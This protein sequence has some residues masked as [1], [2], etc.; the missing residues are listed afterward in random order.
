MD[1]IAKCFLEDRDGCDEMARDRGLTW[2]GD[3]TNRIVYGDQKHVYKFPK[4]IRGAQFNKD[5]FEN[6]EDLLR[7]E[8]LPFGS[9]TPDRICIFAMDISLLTNPTIT[10]VCI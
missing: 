6:G 3:G 2:I 5:E 1:E 7:T 4:N 8:N 9:Y 10:K